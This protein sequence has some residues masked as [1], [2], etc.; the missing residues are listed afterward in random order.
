[1]TKQTS[2]DVHLLPL[3][4]MTVQTYNVLKTREL[5]PD[6]CNLGKILATIVSHII[7]EIA[8]K[9]TAS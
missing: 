9:Q 3:L 2:P 7:I 1:M 8:I 6:K 4:H 5:N